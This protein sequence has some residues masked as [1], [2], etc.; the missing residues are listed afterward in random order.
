MN[1]SLITNI[2]LLKENNNRENK[3]KIIKLDAWQIKQYVYIYIYI[4]IN[5]MK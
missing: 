1:K 2:L 3:D 4:N 5:V